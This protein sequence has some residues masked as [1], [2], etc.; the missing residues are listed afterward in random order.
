[1]IDRATQPPIG[2]PPHSDNARLIVT[3]IAGGTEIVCALGLPT[4]LQNP[5]EIPSG[6]RGCA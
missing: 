3:L 1:M 6:H 4:T 2:E 5:L